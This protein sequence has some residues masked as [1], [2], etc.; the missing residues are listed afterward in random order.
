MDLEAPHWVI[1]GVADFARGGLP[2][3]AATDDGSRWVDGFCWL[4]CG[5]RWTRVLWIGPASVA[6]AQAAMFSCGPCIEELHE[7]V[8]QSILLSDA[9]A[10]PTSSVEPGEVGVVDGRRVG[11]HRGQRR[12]LRRP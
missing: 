3:P 7:R 12:L 4:Y 9:P 11:R 8:W 1:P 2:A 5:Q 6:G 10:R